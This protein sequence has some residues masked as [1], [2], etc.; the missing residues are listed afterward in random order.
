MWIQPEHLSIDRLALLFHDQRMS[1]EVLA[2]R[3]HCIAT[4]QMIE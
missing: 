1:I 3:G 2:G 4:G